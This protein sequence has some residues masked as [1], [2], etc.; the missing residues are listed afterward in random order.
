MD[1]VTWA[2]QSMKDFIAGGGLIGIFFLMTLESMLLPVPSEVVLTFGGWLAFEGRLDLVGVILAG[3]FGCLAGSL[4]AY[5]I[6][7]LGGRALVHRYGRA[8]HVNQKTIDG[9]EAW[10]HKHGDLTVFG[11]RLL[12]VVRT[13]IS[14]PAGLAKMNVPRFSVLT[15]VGSLIWCSILAYAGFLLGTNWQAVEQVSL[16]ITI[17]VVVGTV[18]VLL[19]YFLVVRKKKAR[20]QAKV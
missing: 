10:F 8:L 14:L 3:T 16:P 9:T 6:G 19:W 18:A 15:F 2:I 13:F 20:Q 1:I 11:S 12:P 17:V 4:I 7:D 5:Y